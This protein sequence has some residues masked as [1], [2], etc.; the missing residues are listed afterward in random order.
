M[1]HGNERTAVPGPSCDQSGFRWLINSC[2]MY[3]MTNQSFSTVLYFSNRS[4]L[5]KLEFLNT[6]SPF[7]IHFPFGKKKKKYS[8]L[9]VLI[10]HKHAL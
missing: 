1:A 6:V 8:S 5:R 9:P 10:L 4:N 3:E 7:L 2:Q